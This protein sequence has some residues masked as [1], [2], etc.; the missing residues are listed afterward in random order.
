MLNI[1]KKFSN[2]L[3]KQK[4][5]RNPKRFGFL[6]E[7]SGVIHVGAHNGQE[8]NLYTENGCHVLWIEAN[9]EIF[10]ELCTNIKRH[11]NH[12]A[13][14]A[15]VTDKAQQT[16]DFHVSD[17]QAASSSIFQFKQHKA[18]WPRVN[19]TKTIRV[20]SHTLVT[21]LR[22]HKINPSDYQALVMDTQGS[23]L[24]VL[25]GAASILSNFH[26]IKL[27]VADFE[28]YE[29]CCQLTEI[30]NFMCLQGYKEI[31]RDAFAGK[32]EVGYYYDIVYKKIQTPCHDAHDC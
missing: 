16:Y 29:G 11:N 23:E 12:R 6:K 9:P 17:N 1:F 27:E 15:L 8:R 2:A 13:L 18:I 28:S 4:E 10:R 7:V 30:D 19:F 21:V 20:K 14:Q 5:P 32:P 24:L 31:C 3:Q 26:Y 25:K 22:T